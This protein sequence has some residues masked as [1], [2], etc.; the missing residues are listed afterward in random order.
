MQSTQVTNPLALDHDSSVNGWQ[1]VPRLTWG[2]HMYCHMSIHRYRW[3]NPLCLIWSPLYSSTSPSPYGM[4]PW[5]HICCIVT[6][7]L[8]YF[9]YRG[10]GRE[11]KL[12]PLLLMY[13]PLWLILNGPRERVRDWSASTSACKKSSGHVMDSALM[14]PHSQT[15]DH[16]GIDLRMPCFSH[17]RSMLGTQGLLQG[18][19]WTFSF[20]PQIPGCRDWPYVRVWSI[21]SHRQWPVTGMKWAWCIHQSPRCRQVRTLSWLN[22]PPPWACTPM[23]WAHD[24]IM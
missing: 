24:I 21:G 7:I 17:G 12:P 4:D 9:K 8:L 13:S 22:T 15:V 6:Y 11:R 18:K 23:E 10:R 1:P 16:I 5:H 20:L 3:A 2:W 14:H 19:V